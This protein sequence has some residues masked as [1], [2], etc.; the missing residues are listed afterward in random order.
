M[1]LDIICLSETHCSSN[2][3]NQPDVFNYTWY[4]HCRTVRNRRLSRSFGGVGILVKDDICVQFNITCIDKE[5]DGIM[6]LLFKDNNSD[7][8]F[9]VFVCYLPPEASPWGRDPEAFFNHLLQQVYNYSNVDNMLICGDLNARIGNLKDYIDNVDTIPPRCVLDLVQNNHGMSLIEFLNESKFCIL[10]GRVQTENDN[11]TCISSRGKSIVDYIVVAHDCLA[12]YA[13]MQ[14][15]TP[16]DIV[17]KFKLESML[18]DRC[19]MSDHSVI[20]TSFKATA[21]INLHEQSNILFDSKTNKKFYFN[22]INN[23]FLSNSHWFNI[24]A[25]LERKLSQNDVFQQHI[26][27]CYHTFCHK[28]FMEMDTHIKYKDC[29]KTLKKKFKYHK[30]FWNTELTELWNAMRQAEKVYNK[31]N[32]SNKRQHNYNRALFIDSQKIFNK[33]L[34]NT[35][36]K[37]YAEKAEFIEEINIKDP[38]AFWNTLKCLGPRKSNT[39]PMKV[40]NPDGS[41]TNDITQVYK[42]WGSDFSSLYNSTGDGSDFD[43]IFYTTKFSEKEQKEADMRSPDCPTDL[44]LN[45]A[46]TPQEIHKVVNK[47][48]NKKSTGSDCIPNEVIKTGKLNSFLLHLFNTCFNSG[49]LPS[50]WQESIIVPIPKNSMLDKCV[51]LN[52][53]AI[54]LLS[55]VYKLYTNILNN[56]LNT[57]NDVNGNIVEE[58]NGFRKGRSCLDNIYALTTIIRNRMNQGSNTFCAFV[59]FKKAFDWV[60]R[61]LLLYKLLV[62]YKI[63]GKFYNTIKSLFYNNTASVRLNGTLTKKFNVNVGVRQGDTLSPT[64]FSMYINDLAS[65]I[66]KLCC[67]VRVLDIEVSLLLYADDIVIIAPDEF[68]LQQQLNVLN[69]WCVKWRLKVNENKT[70]II[71]FRQSSRNES[72]YQFHLGNSDIIMVD[73]YKYLGVILYKNLNFRGISEIL[74]EAGVRAFGALRNKLKPLKCYKY[75]TFTKLYHSAVV[76]IMDYAS[77]VW[78]FKC[79]Y[80]AEIV[81]RKAI[82]FYLGVHRYTSNH[83]IEGD[84]GWVSVSTR[85]SLEMLRL[86]NKLVKLPDSRQLRIIFRWDYNI[87]NNNWSS[88]VKAIFE[89]CNLQDCFDHVTLVNLNQAK[90]MIM[91]KYINKWDRERHL[92]DKLRVYNMYKWAFGKEDYVDLNISYMERSL[93]AQFRAGTLPLNIEVGRYRN[94]TLDMR[95]CTVCDKNEVEDEYHV[96][97]NCS[98]YDDLRINL[99]RKISEIDESFL[100]LDPF[101]KFMVICS[102]YQKYLGKFLFLAMDRRHRSVYV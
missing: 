76:P 94:I 37:Y 22:N 51:P 101:D 24:I 15:L 2:I 29:S 17:D 75:Q 44:Y 87:C 92:K 90:T 48:K 95:V 31:T 89:E 80:A 3:N 1:N 9:V 67:G 36:R 58:Q 100:I 30:P 12:N 38:K 85:H 26:D 19:K 63:D 81:Q 57:Y 27:A 4:G 20:W 97:C 56:R 55:T 74:A 93:I 52:Y 82:R 59:D 66:K 70:K 49:L 34:R 68:S 65:E 6:G 54:S 43:E 77:G 69:E 50:M 45:Q 78:G 72:N 41:I 25:E 40:Y 32:K 18:S 46:I 98:L 99:Y 13:T 47:L 61:D 86:W 11:F 28:L 10:N 53:R 60:D 33:C 7:Y 35:E 71:H 102:S 62:N 5:Y 14:V 88:E 96:L 8:S 23:N 91:Q 42:A 39:I 64:L 73:N 83:V 79:N 21:D 84:M 16:N